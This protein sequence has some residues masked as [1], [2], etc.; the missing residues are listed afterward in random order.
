MLPANATGIAK[1]LVRFQAV[2]AVRGGYGLLWLWLD[3]VGLP[4]FRNGYR[5]CEIS[6]IVF[7]FVLTAMQAFLMYGCVNFSL[8]GEAPFIPQM[9]LVSVGFISMALWFSVNE[10]K[11]KLK[12]L[13]LQFH[14]LEQLGTRKFSSLT[15]VL[16]TYFVITHLFYV[17]CIHGYIFTLDEDTD[18]DYSKLLITTKDKCLVIFLRILI[19]YLC[20]L[21]IN[22][23]P[24]LATVL[25]GSVYFRCSQLLSGF[26]MDISAHLSGGR[27]GL[28]RLSQKHRSLFK[29]THSVERSLSSVA[30]MLFCSQ[31]LNMFVGLAAFTYHIFPA[32]A[33]WL[34]APA[35]VIV[36][37]TVLILTLSA[38][39]IRLRVRDIQ[40]TLQN[41]RHC[42]V[43]SSQ[44][45]WESVAVVES[46]LG[47]SFPKMTA[48]GFVELKHR[49]ILSVFGSLFTYG[50][51][52]INMQ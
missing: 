15:W 50:L 32:S 40:T 49:L 41:V 10:K 48:C 20:L 1:K 19:A 27:V 33:L 18:K 52:I 17:V 13:M 24:V 3:I 43:S 23:M 7:V 34:S 2:K 21:V 47:T 39:R 45:E 31:V 16:N 29:L 36:P 42:L 37:S 5:V 9:S 44:I 25:C 14:K 11:K 26:C 6:K 12:T 35:L 8:A 4:L 38:A 22:F 30:L 51:L 46:M 28:I